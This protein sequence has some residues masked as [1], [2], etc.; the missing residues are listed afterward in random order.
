MAL[1]TRKTK[2]ARSRSSSP[3]WSTRLTA[4]VWRQSTGPLSSAPSFRRSRQAFRPSSSTVASKTPPRSSAT[5]PPTI[6]TAARSQPAA[7][8]NCSEAKATSS[9][10]GTPQAARAPNSASR[11][12]WRPSPPSSP[13]SRSSPKTSGLAPTP[14]KL[15]APPSQS[16]MRSNR[17]MASS[18]S[19]SRTT[20]GCSSPSRTASSR[21]K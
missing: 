21:A 6:S 8:A 10:C 18:P 11:G 1:T 7:W 9:C 19:A 5:S 13:K 15:A 17:S 14:M 4:S 20:R 3:R 12:F 2:K 16:S